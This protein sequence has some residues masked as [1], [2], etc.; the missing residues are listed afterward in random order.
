MGIRHKIINIVF[1]SYATAILILNI[2]PDI[3]TPKVERGDEMIRLDYLIHFLVFFLG[4]LLYY[5]WNILR[6]NDHKPILL[7]LFGL[8]Y[9]LT[10]EL[11]QLWIPGRTFNPVDLI[12]N[13]L[14]VVFG[15][16]TPVLFIRIKHMR[17]NEDRR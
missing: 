7:I 6:K 15:L 13:T 11:L 9:A 5:K 10:C 12:Y 14:G 1:W 17:K 2:I 4:G 16:F 3:P 8:I